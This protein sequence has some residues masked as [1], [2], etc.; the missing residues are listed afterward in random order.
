MNEIRWKYKIVYYTY[1]SVSVYA[2]D[3][4]THTKENRR[5]TAHTK[6]KVNV[7][8][9]QGLNQCTPIRGSIRQYVFVA[10][11]IRSWG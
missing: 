6:V 2:W 1:A 4:F 11:R 8:L 7:R 5:H 3:F 10:A 9:K